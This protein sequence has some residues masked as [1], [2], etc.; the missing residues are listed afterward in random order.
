MIFS[1]I[2]FLSVII[3]QL[4]KYLIEKNLVY[5]ESIPII[6]NIFYF[7]YIKN[8]G[9]A[10]GLFSNLKSFLVF[11]TIITI[12]AIFF[13]YHKLQ[14]Q[15]RKLQVSFALILG[16]AFGNLIDRLFWGEVRDFLDFRIWPIFNIADSCIC[17]GIG[18]I[19]LNSFFEKKEHN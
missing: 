2:I 6:K 10:F 18:L 5:G 11:F 12:A 13:Y 14:T 8:N 4:S 17:I 7:T 16:G 1:S 9:V 15:N 3:D 19:L